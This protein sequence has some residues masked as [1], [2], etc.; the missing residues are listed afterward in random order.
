[1]KMTLRLNTIQRTAAVVGLASLC[2]AALPAL[3]RAHED[4]DRHATD[5]ALEGTWTVQVTQRD[6]SSGAPLGVPFYSL[7]T[8]NEGGTMTETTAN[9]MF[10]PA[11]RGPGHGGWSRV[12]GGGYGDAGDRRYQAKSLA[13]ITVNGVLT[14]EQIIRQN[15]QIG[16]NPNTFQTTSA[17]VEFYKPDGSL[18]RRGCATAQGTR[19]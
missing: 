3:A 11:V 7:L 15:I 6:C 14:Q 1:M 9:S 18:L 12:K 2:M 5:T 16:N 10:F 17:S 19:F 8:F 13:L 4:S